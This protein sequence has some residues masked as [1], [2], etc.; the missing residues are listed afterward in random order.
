MLP[1]R[2]ASLVLVIA[3]IFGVVQ[4]DY[5]YDHLD[6]QRWVKFSIKERTWISMRE[7][8]AQAVDASSERLAADRPPG[9][10]QPRADPLTGSPQG[11]TIRR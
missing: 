4:V 3:L 6:R 1:I 5:G 7:L 9:G 2:L 10:P 11:E 8:L